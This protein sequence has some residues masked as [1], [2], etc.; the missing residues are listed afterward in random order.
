MIANSENLTALSHYLQQTL[1]NDRKVG[2]EGAMFVCVLL[3]EEDFARRFDFL[4]LHTRVLFA[5]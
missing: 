3:C 5:A 4:P 1:D 2:R